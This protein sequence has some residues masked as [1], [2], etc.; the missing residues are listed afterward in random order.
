MPHENRR[1]YKVIIISLF[2]PDDEA[3]ER[4]IVVED[5]DEAEDGLTARYLKKIIGGLLHPNIK[6]K[7]LREP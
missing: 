4:E 7:Q 6:L 1:V 2:F 5:E 3:T